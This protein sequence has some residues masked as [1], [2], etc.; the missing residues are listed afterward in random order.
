MINNSLFCVNSEDE[1]E[2]KSGLCIACGRPTNEYTEEAIAVAIVALGTCC[3]RL[4]HTVSSYLVSRIIPAVARYCC[5]I[6]QLAL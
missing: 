1:L 2:S 4:P 6:R 3:H 5:F